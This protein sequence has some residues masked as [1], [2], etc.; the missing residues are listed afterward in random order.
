MWGQGRSWR[1]AAEPQTLVGFW[2][3]GSNVVSAP[4]WVPRGGDTSTTLPSPSHW[5]PSTCLG[6]GGNGLDVPPRTELVFGSSAHPAG[7][8]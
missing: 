8:V 3:W 2:S 1:R 6:W 4:G 5:G 7:A